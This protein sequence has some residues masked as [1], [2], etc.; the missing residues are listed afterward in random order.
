MSN[1]KEIFRVLGD[2]ARALPVVMAKLPEADD[3]ASIALVFEDTVARQPNNNMIVFEGRKITWGEFNELAN[4]LAHALMDRGVKRGNCVAVIMENRIEMLASIIALQKIGAI[5]GMVNPG[6]VGAQLAHCINVTKSV[7]CLAGEE[8]FNSV[9]DVRA[10][11]EMADADILWVADKREGAVPEPME[12]IMA[13]LDS[14]SRANLEDTK[15]I[16][17]GDTGFYIFT[18][19]TTGMPKA[20]KVG[21]RR[22]LAA[23]SS[24]SKAGVR[25]KPSDR[26]YLCLPLFHGTGFICGVNSAIF[27]GASMFLRRKF[28]ASAFWPEVK[29]HNCTIFFYVGELCRYLV[30]QPPCPEEK[31]NPLDRVF[32]NGLRP[33]VWD[34]FKQRFGID[35]VCEFYGSSE[36]NVSFINAF[37]KD[38][39]IGYCP[40]TIILVEYDI[41]NDVIVT[42][43]NGKLIQVE[44]GK[45][46]LLL[47]EIDDRYRFDGYTDSAASES[48]IVRNVLTEGDA[49]FNTGDLINQIDVGFSMGKPHYHFVDRIG[50]TFRWRSENV[51]TNEVGEI[52]NANSQ[53]E[54]ANVYG[55]DVPATE[56]KAGMVSLSLTEGAVFDPVEF[57][58]YVSANLPHFAHPVFVRIQP[59]L[60]TTG[61]FKLVKGELRKQAFHIDRIGDD[62]I[63]VLLPRTNEYKVLDAAT[64]ASIQDGSAGY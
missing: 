55:V 38:K 27:S 37:N 64:Y 11:L 17:A 12:D 16:L 28:S 14:Y 6:L 9:E 63:Y 32:G 23:G 29:E 41:E 36:G 45:P 4:T 18:S 58:T 22:L 48:K 52:L 31:N 34:E 8:I 61:T 53:V 25:A 15:T 13:N 26:I 3:A 10:D 19:G 57:S 33:D 40:G 35:R 30:T 5:A 46:G 21:Q 2:V 62:E 47:A 56:G 39:T 7:K 1:I 60:S 50:D 44:P 49:W 54:I 51:S 59:N 24:F 43:Q 20:A 42:D